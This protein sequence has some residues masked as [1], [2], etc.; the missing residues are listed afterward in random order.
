MR[1]VELVKKTKFLKFNS[2]IKNDILS[3]FGEVKIIKQ[4]VCKE[5]VYY[6]K[7]KNNTNI[8]YVWK[9]LDVCN[10]KSVYNIYKKIN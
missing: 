10:K 6:I 9:E 7:D 4:V 3:F 5:T 1:I 2:Q 8:G